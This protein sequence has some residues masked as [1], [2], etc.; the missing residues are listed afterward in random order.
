[1]VLNYFPSPSFII[2]GTKVFVPNE[3]HVTRKFNRSVLILMSEGELSFLEDG[4]LIT[5]TAGEYYIQ[6]E[7]LLQ[8]GVPLRSL[9]VYFFIEFSATYS[10][11]YAGLPL[12]GTFDAKKIAS[13]T[14]SCEN[15]FIKREADVFKL[16]SYML[17]IFSELL[18]GAPTSNENQNLAQLVCNYIDSQYTSQISLSNISKKFGYTEEYIL[19]IFKKHYGTSPH[20][21]LIQLRMDHAMWLLENTDIS[22]EQTALSVGYT[23]FSAFY[24]SFKKTFGISPS[25]VRKQS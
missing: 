18:R 7:G 11:A 2:C 15:L 19:R 25:T 21:Y 16:N 1:M 22:I 24:R 8:E 20:Q 23:D 4:Q 3:K 17:R 12:R 10:E 9:P 6:R 14:E 5:L 13:L